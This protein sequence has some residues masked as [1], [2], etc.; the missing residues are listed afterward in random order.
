MPGGLLNLISYGNQNIILNGNPSKTFFKSVYAKYSNFGLQNI[1]IDFNGQKT[2]KLNE[3]S[4]F[5]FKIPRNAEL[6]M[7]TFLVFNIPDIWSPIMPPVMP[8]EGDINKDSI[9]VWK[10]Y[11]FKWIEYLGTNIIKKLTLSIGGL[12][13]QSFSG[14]YIQNMV[15]RDFDSSKKELFYNMIGMTEELVNPKGTLNRINDYPNSF[16][17]L[18]PNVNQ[19]PTVPEPSIKGRKIYVPL[20]FWFSYSSKMALP[21]VCLQYSEVT[22]DIVLRPINDLF[23]INDVS[24][25]KTTGFNEELPIRPNVNNEL[26]SFYRFIQP[27]PDEILTAESYKDKNYMWNTDIHLIGTYCF[28]SEEEALVFAKNEQKYLIKDIK[29]DKYPNVIGTK[30]IKLVTNG[31]A[32]TW[33]WYFQRNDNNKRNEWSNYTNW[34]Y[35]N[36]L[37][38]TLLKAPEESTSININ[39]R[40]IGPG[41]NAKYNIEYNGTQNIYDTT[42]NNGYY[43]IDTY[44]NISPKYDKNYTKHILNNLSILFD[45]KYRENVLDAGVYNYIEK[46]K[47]SNGR[48]VDGMYIYNYCLNTNPFEL[49]PSGAINLSKFKTIE[50]EF[51]T[52]LP[53]FDNTS[54]YFSICDNNG[55]VIGNTKNANLYMY[56]YDLTFVEERYNIVRFVSGQAGLVYSR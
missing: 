36:I 51:E 47:M 3:D 32:S 10:P 46:Y 28:L 23:R 11:H 54:E 45:G 35:N 50:V 21:L 52:H 40:N 49:Q 8:T 1:R 26:H 31:M 43:F 7:D 48:S 53:P 9:D 41:L 12:V 20:H 6:L 18:E 37:P 13:I 56:S 4:H 29:E 5:S 2:L 14:Q 30:R 19:I 38:Y 33:M 22:I 25:T 24:L 34:P 55:N 44:Y 27:P 39:G 42:Q 15:E 17:T 16:Y